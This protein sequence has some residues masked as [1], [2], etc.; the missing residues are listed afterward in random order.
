M[1]AW[2]FRGLPVSRRTKLWLSG[3]LEIKWGVSYKLHASQVGFRG[4][5]EPGT[6]RHHGTS[7]CHCSPVRAFART[8]PRQPLAFAAA[9]SALSRTP[10]AGLRRGAASADRPLPL[11]GTHVSAVLL[12]SSMALCFLAPNPKPL[13]GR[14]RFMRPSPTKRS[15]LPLSLGDD[16]RSGRKR[17]RA[18]RLGTL[19][20]G[21]LE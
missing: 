16:E 20:F 3:L 7:R 13:S 9:G 10:P 19:V 11:C 21:S 5:G 8:E 6:I 2:L 4:I 18:A 17:P 14:A 1:F 12:R 15:C